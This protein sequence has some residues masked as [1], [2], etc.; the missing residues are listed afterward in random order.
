VK[1]RAERSMCVAEVTSPM[2]LPDPAGSSSA[3][4]V[5]FCIVLAE[6]VSVRILSSGTPNCIAM[7]F[8]ISAS[9]SAPSPI[10]PPQ[11]A[12]SLA[13]PCRKRRTPWYRRG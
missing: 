9:L 6:V 2:R 4:R 10:A 11:K 13:W 1:V 3:N 5:T 8:M 7:A 12:R